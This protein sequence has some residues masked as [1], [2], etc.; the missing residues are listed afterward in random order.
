MKESQIVCQILDYLAAE[1]IFAFRLNTSAFKGEHKG[2]SWFT[3][4]HSLGPGAADIVATIPQE[5]CG[6]RKELDLRFQIVTWIECKTSTGKQSP[7]QRNFQEHVE[8]L[9][10]RYILARSVDNVAEL[11]EARGK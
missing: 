10:H 4:S 7:Q 5:Y 3:R 11:W 2:K 9:G 1:R 8:S 6:N